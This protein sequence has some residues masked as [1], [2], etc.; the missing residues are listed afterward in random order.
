MTTAILW[1]VNGQFRN[2]CPDI[3]PL[4]FQ[5]SQYRR[6]VGGQMPRDGATE[7]TDLVVASEAGEQPVRKIDVKDLAGLT[8]YEKKC[9]L[10]NREIDAIG[11]GRYQWTVW[12]LCGFGYMIDL[13]WAQAFGL[14][15][16]PMQQ[17][18]G[19]G[20][21]QT[22]NITSSFNAGRYGRRF[23]LGCLGGRRRWAFNFTVLFASV[24]GL[25]LGASGN[26][27]TF[28]VLT[29]FVGFGVGGNVP[30]DTTIAL[31]FIPQN[32]R[33]LLA[34]LSIFQPI[35]VVVCSAIA[36]GFIPTRSCSPNFSEPD[37]LPSCFKAGLEPGAPCCSRESNMGW[38]YFL[39]TLGA[40]TL[41]VLVL[42]SAVFRLKESPKFLLCSG[43]D[44]EAVEVVRYIAN[45]NGR[46]CNLTLADLERLTRE[47]D[48]V[49][50]SST[51][52]DRGVRK[53][54]WKEKALF[55]G[56]RYMLLFNSWQMARLTLLVWLTY[57]FDFWGFTVAGAYLPQI[58][59]LKN[60]SASK[61]LQFTYA[62]YIYTYAPGILGVLLGAVM[63]R[64]PSIGRKWTMTLASGLMGASIFLFAIVD[65][66]PKNL[67][68]FTLE[69]F[70]QSMFNAVLYGWT[71]EAFPAPVRGSACGI[72][73]FWGRLFGII[74]PLIAQRLYASSTDGAND[75]GGG[76]INAVLYL[77]GGITLGC[78]VTTA[79][80]PSEKLETADEMS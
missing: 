22:G 63:Y 1:I 61:S 49:G 11:M 9:V 62:S 71:P 60:G 56:N 20:S 41:S 68:L 76:N 13:L 30:I 73:S 3:P 10:I 47:E 32:K 58:L 45:K 53:P 27:T 34:A 17:E 59:A 51:A 26:Y 65:T 4:E 31:E 35:G 2:H 14:V 42:R 67:G 48:S 40:I 64:L 78:V 72:A 19:F 46:P 6:T 37:P 36:F 21:G 18:F 54:S 33:F 28:L 75:V 15:L 24:F 5:T 80:L 57:I 23:C 8:L 66:V 50:S 79:L 69:Y 25:G 43:R 74:S 52:G 77:A 44:A 16:S 70:F 29:A 38:R 39:Y 55:G 12:G 7:A